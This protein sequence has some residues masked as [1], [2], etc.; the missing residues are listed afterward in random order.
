M[1]QMKCEIHVITLKNQA[2]FENMVATCWHMC[3]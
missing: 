3:L 2:E 1:Q